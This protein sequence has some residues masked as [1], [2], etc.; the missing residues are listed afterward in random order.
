MD[1]VVVS[2]TGDERTGQGGVGFTL[3]YGAHDVRAR[4]VAHGCYR[5]AG[6]VPVKRMNPRLPKG[7]RG[8]IESV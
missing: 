1:V 7:S 3:Q 8:F 4:V 6:C 2:T 5:A